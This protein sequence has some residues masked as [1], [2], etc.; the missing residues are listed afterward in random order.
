MKISREVQNR[1]RALSQQEG[2]TM[3]AILEKALKLYEERAFWERTNRAYAA[4]KTN[5][6][7]SGQELEERREWEVTLK[8]GLEDE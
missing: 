2:N 8:D 6:E 5:P 1:L 7:T 4:L 3:Q